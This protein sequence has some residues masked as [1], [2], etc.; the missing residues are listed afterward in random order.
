MISTVNYFSAGHFRRQMQVLL[1]QCMN[2]VQPPTSP[3]N[4]TSAVESIWTACLN[5]R[6]WGCEDGTFQTEMGMCII[7]P[8]KFRISSGGKTDLFGTLTDA[9]NYIDQ[10]MV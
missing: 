7:V 4:L 5:T 1:W 8:D 9:N 3:S 2:R 10:P 6:F